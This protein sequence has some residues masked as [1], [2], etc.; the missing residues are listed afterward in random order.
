VLKHKVKLALPHAHAQGEPDVSHTIED[1]FQQTSAFT[2][3][4]ILLSNVELIIKQAAFDF[5]RDYR[6]N[7]ITQQNWPDSQ[8]IILSRFLPMLQ[9]LSKPLIHRPLLKSR[10]I[11]DIQEL[12]LVIHQIRD[13]NSS[14]MESAKIA[15]ILNSCVALS[16]VIKDQTAAI[17][18]SQWEE[19]LSENYHQVCSQLGSEQRACRAA[20]RS[21]R[22]PDVNEASE[23]WPGD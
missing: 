11:K 8:S 13:K 18:L 12:P 20:R 23:R 15:S 10:V 22:D 9:Q 3:L 17:T 1:A 4:T 19:K 5:L 14:P 7:T 21:M 16:I 6:P 2:T